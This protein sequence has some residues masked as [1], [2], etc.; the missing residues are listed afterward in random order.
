MTKASQPDDLDLPDRE[1][2]AFP[3][4]FVEQAGAICLRDI[5][6][7]VEVLLITSRRSGRWGIPKG[8]IE[9]GEMPH[10]T[11]RREACEEAGIAGRVVEQAAGHFVYLK[12]G[13]TPHYRVS[14]HVLHV[15]SI[16]EPF[17]EQG[18]RQIKWVPLIN[19]S[20]AVGNRHLGHVL[21]TVCLQ[22][23]AWQ[24]RPER[25]FRQGLVPSRSA[26]L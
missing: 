7:R 16:Q 19:A 23:L 15:T 5:R 4:M 3:C 11:A 8:H 6:G 20:Q 25:T 12:P 21:D 24:D 17:P 2:C 9:A 14:L 26:V 10:E 13:R 1:E 18:H 22:Y